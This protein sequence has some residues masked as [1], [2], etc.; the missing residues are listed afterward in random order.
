MRKVTD[1]LHDFIKGITWFDNEHTY[2][3]KEPAYHR[4]GPETRTFV[5]RDVKSSLAI[6]RLA[7]MRITTQTRPSVFS[8]PEKTQIV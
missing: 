7:V 6:A 4:P 3:P 2:S 5:N 1:T 8:R